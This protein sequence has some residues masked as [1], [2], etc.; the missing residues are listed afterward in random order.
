MTKIVP[1]N[2]RL[3]VKKIEDE[4]RTKSGLK[5][6][7]DTKERPTKG[8]V[9]AVGSGRINDDGVI[10]PMTIKIG[11][12]VLYPKYAGHPAKVDNEEYL[13]IEEKEVLAILKEG[14]MNNG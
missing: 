2:D 14:E 8:T 4:N 5:L 11:D 3:V 1:T 12:I 9:L 13:I 10:L 6:S 7:D